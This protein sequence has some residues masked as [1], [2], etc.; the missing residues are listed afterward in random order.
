MIFFRFLILILFF[1]SPTIFWAQNLL[2]NPSFED[3]IECPT[4]LLQLDL[5]YNWKQLRMTGSLI[6]TCSID[7]IE[8]DPQELYHAPFEFGTSYI[9]FPI[10]FPS[11]NSIVQDTNWRAFIRGELKQPL[12]GKTHYISFYAYNWQDDRT[13]KFGFYF[14][15]EKIDTFL[16]YPYDIIPHLEIDEWIGG[17]HYW[18]LHEGCVGGVNGAKYVIL[19]NFNFP[20]ND[21]VEF[22]QIP[23]SF[24]P[25]FDNFT[26]REVPEAR[27]TLIEGCKG[28]ILELDTIFYGLPIEYS[29][30]D[31]IVSKPKIYLS[32]DKTILQRVRGCD[33]ILRYI[34]VKTHEC[35]KRIFI[36]NAFTPNGDGIN[37][38]FEIFVE[39]YSS[40]K[41]LELQIFNRWGERVFYSIDPLNSL[42]DGRF[43][44]KKLNSGSFVWRLKY[45]YL[46]ATK[47]EKGSKEGIV[48]LK[49]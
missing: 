29:I 35:S 3:K 45:E 47:W 14:T 49:R 21:Q 39:N 46:S 20:G 15:D 26:I 37:D 25:Y 34:Y 18:K 7:K 2:I 42:W 43:G 5:A 36:P 23:F 28:T 30:L 10:S 44:G 19:G 33:E 40:I 22:N 4:K 41:V 12:S 11:T 32:H 24:A 8:P 9:R 6:D 31:T 1:L 17:Y 27:D 13:N 16:S 38:Y 48:E